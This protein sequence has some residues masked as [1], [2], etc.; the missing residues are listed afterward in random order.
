MHAT[1]LVKAM[2]VLAPSAFI[3]ACSSAPANT[4]FAPTAS[5]TPAASVEVRYA[6]VSNAADGSVS[7]I[8]LRTD[9]VAGTVKIGQMGAHGIAASGDGLVGYAALEGANEV[10]VISGESQSVMA[11]IPVPFSAGMAQHGVDISPD[12][13]YLW[14]GARQGGDNRG[15]VVLAELAVVNTMTRQVEKVIQTGLG[16]PAHY[17]MTP[18]GAELW[19][20]STTVDLVWVVDAKKR[21]VVAAIPMVP[22]ASERTE[23]QRQPLQAAK[24]IALNE[25]AISPDGKR[26]YAVGPVHDLVFVVDV[27]TRKLVGTVKSSKNAHGVV[28]SR[29]GKEVWT[30]DWA[31]TLTIIDADTLKVK[32]TVSLGGR[33]NHIAFSPDGQKVYVTKTGADPEVGEV[34]VL[35]K[36]SRKV[37]T[38]L[39]VGKSPHEISLEDAPIAQ[40]GPQ[41]SAGPTSAPSNETLPGQTKQDSGAG[42][43]T[44]QASSATSDYLASKG[45]DVKSWGFLVQIDTHSGDLTGIDMVG[46]TKLRD[47]RGRSFSPIEWHGLSEDSHHRSGLLIFSI[48][49]SG[50]EQPTAANSG[51]V[52]LVLTNVANEPERVLR[53]G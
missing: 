23:A 3:L 4:P 12:G 8:D 18:D 24:I 45:H 19:V 27:P 31:G 10:V 34:V 21:E 53:W 6:Y 15:E 43:V 48:D 33:P 51:Y 38:T 1:A 29:D 42:G 5:V 49:Q 36:A 22:P 32:D 9:A 30:S 35:N 28:V 41:P 50:K 46:Q 16:V 26:A 52:E 17:A 14:I 47:G 2:G 7:V 37:L 44:F 39:R 40:A 20:A 13:E 25:V 11:R